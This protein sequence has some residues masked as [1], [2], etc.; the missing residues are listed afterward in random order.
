MK[1]TTTSTKRAD[2]PGAYLIFHVYILLHLTPSANAHQCPQRRADLLR[3]IQLETSICISQQTRACT[4]WPPDLALSG[5]C[6]D[7]V[8]FGLPKG[9]ALVAKRTVQLRIRS[10]LCLACLCYCGLTGPS[11]QACLLKP[12]ASIALLRPLHV[13]GL[14]GLYCYRSLSLS[15]RAV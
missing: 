7:A 9:S 2:C 12:T 15:R 1:I 8:T 11:G 3:C 13:E 5:S 10:T 6:V 14:R 4:I